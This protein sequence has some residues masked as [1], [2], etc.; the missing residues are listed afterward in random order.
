MY[1]IIRNLAKPDTLAKDTNLNNP[2]SLDHQFSS[3]WNKFLSKGLT[4]RTATLGIHKLHSSG[5]PTWLV[6]ALIRVTVC[7]NCLATLL[8]YHFRLSSKSNPLIED[9]DALMERS[10]WPIWIWRGVP[11]P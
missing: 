7:D 8:I 6:A 11:F 10:L 4:D 2:E 1:Q 5:G 9:K 3:M